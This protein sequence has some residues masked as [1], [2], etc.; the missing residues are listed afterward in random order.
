M[1]CSRRCQRHDWKN[2]HK[3]FHQSVED[4]DLHNRAI[5]VLGHDLVWKWTYAA[6]FV[7]WLLLAYVVPVAGTLGWVALI[8]AALAH[9][10]VLPRVQ[11][12]LLK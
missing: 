2:G 11:I 4:D 1:Y 10:G 9:L 5:S 8:V 12:S 6:M 7:L 3:A